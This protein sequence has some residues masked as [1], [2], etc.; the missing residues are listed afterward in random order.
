MIGH[1][2]KDCSGGRILTSLSATWFVSYLYYLKI[3]SSHLNWNKFKER[4]PNFEKSKKYHN[5]WLKKIVDKN[6]LKL[7]KNQIGLQGIRVKEMAQEL[8]KTIRE[9]NDYGTLDSKV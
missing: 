2:Y 1:I 4:I 5:E 6:P 3:D 9:E 7:N 8:L